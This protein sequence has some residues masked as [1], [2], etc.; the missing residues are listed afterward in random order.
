LFFVNSR[1]RLPLVPALLL[2]SAAGLVRFGA[3]ARSSR[4]RDLALC[5]TLAM[6]AMVLAYLPIARV[7]ITIAEATMLANI[8]NGLMEERG[9]VPEA[10]TYFQEAIRVD[11]RHPSAH[12][13]LGKALR[14]LGRNQEAVPHLALAVDLQPGSPENRVQLGRVLSEVGRLGDAVVQYEAAIA[15]DPGN[16]WA[17]YWAANA[18]KGLGREPEARRH[19]R[20]AARLNPGFSG[21]R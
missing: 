11:P 15:S 9:Q 3:A 14:R 2:F 8:G 10:I 4:R 7:E 20:E 17:H 21:F 5:F 16:A 13:C 1:F 19:M 18:L 12:A 6:S